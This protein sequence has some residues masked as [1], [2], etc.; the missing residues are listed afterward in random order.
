M[1]LK[2]KDEDLLLLLS[3]LINIM[4]D[5]AESDEAILMLLLTRNEIVEG[6]PGLSNLDSIIIDILEF[7]SSG[8]PI[9]N[10]TQR[11]LIS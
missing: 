2:T 3:S 10:T 11:N 5:M 1:F 4:I 9:K 7:I 6:I 8:L